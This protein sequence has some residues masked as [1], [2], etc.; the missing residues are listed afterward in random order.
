[1]M[2]SLP[3]VTQAC[4]SSFRFS[5]FVTP[6]CNSAGCAFWIRRNCAASARG[7]Q[8]AFGMQELAILI[9]RAICCAE[10][11]LVDANR[12]DQLASLTKERF[13]VIH[14]N[15]LNPNTMVASTV[16]AYSKSN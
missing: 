13:K 8:V 6:I 10:G 7:R 12:E 1:M 3:F 4:A 16:A 15:S 14:G 2:M 11:R 9:A 5:F